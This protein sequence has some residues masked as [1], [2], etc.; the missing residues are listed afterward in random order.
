MPQNKDACS[1]SGSRMRVTERKSEK[2]ED[3]RGDSRKVA[4]AL[5][6]V[7]LDIIRVTH[8][9]DC[10][11]QGEEVVRWWRRVNK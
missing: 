2:T 9:G 7:M 10:T 5:G 4:V 11:Y 1:Q 8:L 6:K 3:E